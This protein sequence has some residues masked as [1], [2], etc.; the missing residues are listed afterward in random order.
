MLL[1]S[2]RSKPATSAETYEDLAGA[3][4]NHVGLGLAMAV[5]CFS[6][7]GL[8]LTVG[9][10]GKFY[11]AAPALRAGD[12]WLVILMMINAAIGAAYYLRIVAVMFL[13][14]DTAGAAQSIQSK[15]M[16][17]LPPQPPVLLAVVISALATLFFGIV[18]PAYREIL[19]DPGS[20]GCHCRFRSSVRQCPTNTLPPARPPEL[21]GLNN[22]ADF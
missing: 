10:F 13:G 4:R 6:L 11:L 16:N 5:G 1:P 20:S 19:S 15:E 3:G 2:R 18:L 22:F 12:V 17:E 8:P 14:T 7:T 9:F 21:F